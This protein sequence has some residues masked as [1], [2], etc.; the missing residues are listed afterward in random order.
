MITLSGWSH[1]AASTKLLLTMMDAD[2][3]EMVEK[4]F[5]WGTN[6][7]LDRCK[8]NF[9]D[10]DFNGTSLKSQWR[11]PMADHFVEKVS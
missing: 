1:K 2:G 11:L 7:L 6:F 3:T 4:K 5:H 9:Y 10:L 8:P